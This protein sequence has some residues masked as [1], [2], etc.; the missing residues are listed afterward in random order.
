MQKRDLLKTIVLF[1]LIVLTTVGSS[2]LLNLVT[3]PKIASDAA[4]REELAAQQAAGELLQVLPGATGFED[5]TSTLELDANRLVISMHKEVSGKGYAF[6]AEDKF[7]DMVNKAKVTVGVD[8]EGKIAGVIVSIT[9]PDFGAS[10]DG[11]LDATLGSLVGLDS[12][13]GGFVNSANATH[14]S[15]A[16]KSSIAAGFEVLTKNGLMTAAS[17][18]EEQV[19]EE[20][21]L[22]VYSNF[23][24]DKN[25]ELTVSGNITRA[26]K[27]S[28]GSGVVCYVAKGD[29]KLM[30]I[31]NIGGIVK[32][33]QTKLIDEATQKYEL[34]EV[35][36]LHQ[37]VVEEVSAFASGHVTS[38]QNNLTAKIMELYETATDVSEIQVT[39]FDD[40]V[41]AASFVV[42]GATYYGF[43]AKPNNAF[44]NLPMDLFVI[45]DSEGKI[46]KLDLGSL[47]NLFIELEYFNLKLP[48]IIEF[49]YHEYEDKFIE[50]GSDAI[51]DSSFEKGGDLNIAGATRSS[52]AVKNGVK[53][54]FDLYNTLQG[55]NK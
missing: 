3:G 28:S 48:G 38:K 42:D 49:P 14:S 44:E 31:Y 33:Y 17:K 50:L 13:L 21:L 16:V 47:E 12:T 8:S 5:I 34:E 10:G 41:A 19:F 20:Q 52:V 25:G 32:V 15:N 2:L 35:T 43:Y 40:V 27:A 23:I 9:A 18:T 7:G 22:S 39:T 4:K 24:M 6:V 11:K 51:L 45:I 54:A 26:M 1:A 53:A 55:G 37:D 30:A 46:A 29:A 36:S